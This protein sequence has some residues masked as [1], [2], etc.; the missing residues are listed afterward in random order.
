VLPL[1]PE[2]FDDKVM[3]LHCVGIELQAVTA[4]ARLEKSTQF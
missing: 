1:P 3:A 4:S 2:D